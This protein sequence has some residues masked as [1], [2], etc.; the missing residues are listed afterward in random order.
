MIKGEGYSLFVDFWTIGVLAFHLFTGE[1]PFGKNKNSQYDIF[2]SI[3][4][5]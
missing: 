5:E 4:E 2:Q 1:V 3:L